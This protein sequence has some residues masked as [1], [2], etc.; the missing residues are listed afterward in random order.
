M[1]YN[2]LIG[3]A[4]GQG[5]V[6]ISHL[7]SKLLQRQGF[8]LFSNKDY[9][10]RVRGGHNFIQIRFGDEPID[11]FEKKVDLIIALNQE[12]LDNHISKLKN[13][14]K[15]LA[16]ISLVS[17]DARVCN[18]SFVEKSKEL[19]SH[20]LINSLFT[21]ALFKSFDLKFDKLESVFQDLFKDKELI[22]SNL[23]AFNIAYDY[24]NTS[25]DSI[26][27]NFTDSILISGSESIALGAIT[28]GVGF[29]SAYPMS[30]STGIMA[31]LSK[32]QSDAKIVVEQAED[33]I[34]AIEAAMGSSYAGLRSMTA[35]SGGGFSLMS[36]SL[37]FLGVSEIPLVVV[38][39]QRPGPATGLPTRTSQGDLS[40]VVSAGH[41]E[42]PKVVMAL[43]DVETAFYDIQRALNLADK[44]QVPVI[45]LGDQFLVDSKVTIPPFNFNKIPIKP[46]LASND[47]LRKDYKRYEITEHGVSPRI[48]PSLYDSLTLI[49]DSHEHDEYGHITEDPDMVT[50][51]V[52]KRMR[53]LPYISEKMEEPIYFGAEIPDVLLISWGSAMSPISEA[54]SVLNESK[55]VGALIFKD[56]YPLPVEFLFKYTSVAHKIINVEHNFEGQLAKLIKQETGISMTDSLLRYDG[57]QLSFED[58]VDFVDGRNL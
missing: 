12:T 55:N 34:G 17:N 47:F 3:G 53:K 13:K 36:E 16:D 41:G 18:Y 27:S 40:F 19:G 32:K 29:Y 37:S 57:R 1:K 24:F 8:Y 15:V 52:H 5:L 45:V 48:L 11:T 56:I 50:A 49:A 42:F 2:I 25:F 35:T 7:I 28:G 30:P 14:G 46:C 31:Y 33:E 4:A 22:K 6:T 21:G 9:M 43:T 20:Y 58:I 39:V 10:S 54:V 26:E 51:Q 44:F 23:E 38:D